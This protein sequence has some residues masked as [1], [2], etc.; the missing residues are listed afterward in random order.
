MDWCLRCP[1]LTH[2]PD[3]SQR[4]I[5]GYSPLRRYV[6]EHSALLVVHPAASP[7]LLTQQQLASLCADY[8]S[9]ANAPE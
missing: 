6:A 9:P 5:L 3:G 4:M 1:R 8:S 2:H 7:H